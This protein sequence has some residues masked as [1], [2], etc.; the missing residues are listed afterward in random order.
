MYRWHIFP[1]CVKMFILYI[2]SFW[3]IV[4]QLSMAFFNYDVHRLAD[5]D[6]CARNNGGCQYKCI[7]VGDRARCE[8]PRGQE[9]ASDGRSC[10]G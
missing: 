1:K 9:L 3:V 10:V 2:A 6:P 4:Y 8:C 5:I 7:G